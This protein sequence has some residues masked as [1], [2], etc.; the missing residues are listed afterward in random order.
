MTDDW[1]L[2]VINQSFIHPSDKWMVCSYNH[3]DILIIFIYK[4]PHK[5]LNNLKALKFRKYQKNLEL[6]DLFPSA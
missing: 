5:F 4:L 6:R 1:S 3:V 2:Y